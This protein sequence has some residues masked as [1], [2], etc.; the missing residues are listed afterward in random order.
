MN[1]EKPNKHEHQYNYDSKMDSKHTSVVN[2]KLGA[3]DV[4]P[5]LKIHYDGSNFKD[6]KGPK[7]YKLPKLRKGEKRG[8]VLFRQIIHPAG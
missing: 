4:N 7:K 6:T 1:I 5:L 2:R 3:K 8:R